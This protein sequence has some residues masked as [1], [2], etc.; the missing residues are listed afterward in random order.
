MA[1][2]YEEGFKGNKKGCPVWAIVKNASLAS[3]IF[4]LFFTI[5][6]VLD[7]HK[8]IAVR[9]SREGGFRAIFMERE[10]WRVALVHILILLH[11]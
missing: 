6:L 2:P 4:L 8:F 3:T 10:T 1:T 5:V 7:A 11:E 9:V